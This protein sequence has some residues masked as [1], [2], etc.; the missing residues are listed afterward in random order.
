MKGIPTVPCINIVLAEVLSLDK[1]SS[2]CHETIHRIIS[3][4]IDLVENTWTSRS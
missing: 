4:A 2:S 1:I 3:L